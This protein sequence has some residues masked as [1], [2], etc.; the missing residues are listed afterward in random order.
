MYGSRVLQLIIIILIL[1]AYE[2][3]KT[4]GIHKKVQFE[5]HRCDY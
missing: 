1:F 2:S 4:I 5:G 3:L